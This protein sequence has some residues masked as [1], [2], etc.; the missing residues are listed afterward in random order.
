M[1]LSRHAPVDHPLALQFRRAVESLTAAQVPDSARQYRGT[2][3][4]F[5]IYLGDDHPAVCSLN[6]LRRDPHILGWFTHLRS[7]A[8]AVYISRLMHLRCIL[9]ELAWTAQLPDLAHLIRRGDVPRA[10]QRLPRA[11]TAPQDQLIQQELLRRND[12]PA[13][14]FLL[15]RHTG[16]RIGE[17]VDLSWNCLRNVGPDRWAIHVPLGKLK[18]E[19]MVPVDS[20]VCELVQRLRFF[21][22][23]DPLPPD[24]HLLARPH[25]KHALIR[26]LRPYL[27]EV[28]AAVGIPT[29]IVPH[30]LR[31]TYASEMVRSGVTLPALMK[32]LGHTD[33]G[34][35]MRYVEVASN[36]L[37]REFHLARSRPRHLAPHPKAPTISPRA[38]L[39]GVVDSL[40]FA[41]HAIE[42]FRRSLPDG[43]PRRCLDRLSNRLTKILSEARKLSP[44][45]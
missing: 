14:V 10:P 25:G 12:L 7:L 6:Q 32:L 45:G 43:P 20:F 35:T 33:P 3:R 38:G 40:L 42:M 36:D 41:Q 22:S 2:A 5:L 21:R 8:P 34:M 27:H 15:L 19:R 31:H 4:N 17:C 16:M 11:L 26:Q 37:Q 30:Q 24:G 13:N 23:F 44:P 9:E 39:D 18:T 1:K 29:R 28:S